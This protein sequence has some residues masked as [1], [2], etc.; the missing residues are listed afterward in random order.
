MHYTSIENIHKVIDPLFLDNLKAEFDE[1]KAITVVRTR[2]RK[3]REFQD[4]L[5]ELI[6]LDPAAGS[7]N[8]LTESYLCIRRLENAVI[9]TLTGGQI[10]IAEVSDPI[11]VS[12]SQ[13]HGI[14]INDFAVTVAKTALWIAESQMMKETEEIIHMQL[15]FLPL[16]TNAEIVEGNA[17]RLDWNDVVDKSELNYIM[18]NPPFRGGEL[19]ENQKED[20]KNIFNGKGGELDYVA[21]WYKKAADFI[22]NNQIKCA[23]VSTN[24]ICQGQQVEPLWKNLMDS[25]IGIDYAYRTFRW[26]SEANLKAKVSCI[27]VGFSRR[28]RKNAI[29]YNNGRSEV[30]DNINGYLI[31]APNI[32][33]K[34]IRTPLDD[35]PIVI[36]G[37]QPTDNGYLILNDE[38][39]NQLISQEPKSEKWI[40]PFITAK[41]YLHGKNRWCLW[42]IGISPAEL[43]SL[44]KVRERVSLCREWRLSQKTSGDAYKL[45]DRPTLMRPSGK[46]KDGESF[47]ILPRHSSENRRVIPFGFAEAGSIPGDSISI[48]TGATLYHFGVMESNVHMAWTRA[49]CGRLEMRYRYTSDL[50]YNTFPWPNPS[51]QQKE[52]IEKT[53]QMILDARA[54]YPDSSLADL[55]DDLTMPP[56]LRRAH[57]EN[58]K[59]V[60]RAYGFSIKDTTEASCVAELM[61]MYQELTK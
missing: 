12:I 51:E 28:N 33:V 34:K 15:D 11:K 27:I 61:R 22:E 1:I 59:A 19:S 45:R 56:E 48:A 54:K 7:G 5:A 14:E 3:L 9:N 52:T 60:M 21:C 20:R 18:G 24:S 32:F 29:L 41:E 57:Q 31:A 37:F 50:V 26:D 40:K 16:K 17:L 35:V 53:A 4:K 49:V 10:S 6:F 58:D 43:N 39:K 2:E 46:F 38:E 30:V 13:F 42:L 55:Y 36:K 47:I 8:F 44:P 25:G 23:F